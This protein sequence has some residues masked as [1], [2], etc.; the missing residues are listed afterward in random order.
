MNQT[1]IRDM[2]AS[3]YH[4]ARAQLLA[5][6]KLASDRN[7]ATSETDHVE[8]PA[9]IHFDTSNYSSL[10]R[11]SKNTAKRIA[12]LSASEYAKARKDLLSS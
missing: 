6:P 1:L 10:P 5:P 4:A 7:E 11:A 12:D 9:V 3:E 2:T 8:L